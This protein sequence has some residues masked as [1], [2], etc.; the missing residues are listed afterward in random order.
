[1]SSI[2]SVLFVSWMLLVGLMDCP[3]YVCAMQV[4]QGVC[5]DSLLSVLTNAVSVVCAWVMVN[6]D[7]VVA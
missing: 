6:W 7:A 2:I 3:W 1:M 4:R 5:W